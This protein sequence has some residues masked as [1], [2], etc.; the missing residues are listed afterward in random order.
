M[1]LKVHATMLGYYDLLRRY[2]EDAEHPRAGEV[3]EIGLDAIRKVKK[4]GKVSDE[5]VFTAEGLLE[6]P[7]WVEPESEEEY[8]SW[9]QWAKGKFAKSD[10]S[11]KPEQAPAVE[12]VVLPVAK[13]APLKKAAS[14]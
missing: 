3:F 12:A 6:L 7:R 10:V 14:K 13:K 11:P 4:G 1:K 2:P 9:S 8:R 5:P